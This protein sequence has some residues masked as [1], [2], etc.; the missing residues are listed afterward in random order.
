VA[1]TFQGTGTRILD[2]VNTATDTDYVGRHFRQLVNTG[3][4]GADSLPSQSS[5]IL[6][7]W[8]MALSLGSDTTAPFALAL[9]YDSL[10]TNLD[11][12]KAGTIQL[13][14]R[15][16]TGNWQLAAAR[17]ARGK[18]TFV[19]RP[20]KSGDSLGVYGVD[21]AAHQVWAVLDRAADFAVAALPSGT[22]RIRSGSAKTAIPVRLEGRTL[23]SDADATV[24]LKDLEG[25]TVFSKRMYKGQSAS[26]AC[27]AGMYV[28]RVQGLE[29]RVQLVR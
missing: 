4:S 14:A 7:L 19:V 15:D 27:P 17:N 23:T 25:R 10:H 11:S 1:D 12:L 13:V 5:R 26:L 28:L 24:Q 29:S 20:W 8:G 9:S 21:T 2:G 3:W 16:T 22:A 6:G 18:A